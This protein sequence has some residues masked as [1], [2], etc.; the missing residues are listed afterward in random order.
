M[1]T[2]HYFDGP[3]RLTVTSRLGR[4]RTEKRDLESVESFLSFHK[5]GIVAMVII[6]KKKPSISSTWLSNDAMECHA[7]RA[8]AANQANTVDLGR[9]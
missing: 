5:K 9:D 6:R 3:E 4:L 8:T 1:E 7:T 2:I